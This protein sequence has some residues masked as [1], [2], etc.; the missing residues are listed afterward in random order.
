MYWSDVLRA[1][2]AVDNVLNPTQIPPS[3]LVGDARPEASI[4]YES[5]HAQGLRLGLEFGY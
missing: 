4:D 5:F 2:N 3:Q 1:G